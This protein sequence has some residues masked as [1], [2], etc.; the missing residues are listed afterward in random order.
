MYSR[1]TKKGHEMDKTK[2]AELRKFVKSKGMTNEVFAKNV[3]N[4]SRQEFSYKLNGIIAFSVQDI[5]IIKDYF[6]LSAKQVIVFF[7]DK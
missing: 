7:F 3:L 6:H 1:F 4:M 5:Q 2:Y